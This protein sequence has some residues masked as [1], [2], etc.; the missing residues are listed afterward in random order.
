[1]ISGFS[2]LMLRKNG[3]LMMSCVGENGSHRAM[4]VSCNKD[5]YLVPVWLVLIMMG[6]LS[7]KVRVSKR[8]H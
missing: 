6:G 7:N 1:M 4:R 8:L 2:I 5:S 3:T